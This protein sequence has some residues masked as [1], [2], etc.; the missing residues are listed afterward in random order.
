MEVAPQRGEAAAER[1]QPPYHDLI[2]LTT[3]VGHVPGPAGEADSQA[4][5]MPSRVAKALDQRIPLVEQVITPTT[6]RAL[7]GGAVPA[8]EKIGSLLLPSPRLF[9]QANPDSQSHWAQ[10]LASS[11]RGR[12]HQ[13]HA[14]L[15]GNPDAQA[16][17]PLSFNIAANRVGCRPTC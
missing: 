17:R 7:Q 5:A 13:H 14:V 3:T 1:L 2:D 9:A 10:R 4:R 15:D 6:R 8:S 16:P 11:S 12:A